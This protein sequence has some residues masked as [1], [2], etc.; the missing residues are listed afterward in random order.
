MKFKFKMSSKQKS[1]YCRKCLLVSSH[2]FF[3]NRGI[4]LSQKKV[5]VGSVVD[6]ISVA[7]P[8]ERMFINLVFLVLVSC[9]VI[10]VVQNVSRTHMLRTHDVLCL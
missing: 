6:G 7:V 3:W 8:F 1:P 9:F 2:N 5:A 4:R 10:I